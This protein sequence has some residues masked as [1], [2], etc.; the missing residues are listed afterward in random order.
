MDMKKYMKMDKFGTRCNLLRFVG[1]GWYG[2][3][4]ADTLLGE[5]GWCDQHSAYKLLGEIGH[6]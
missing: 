3:H 4:S 2:Q 1:T 5:I 6:A